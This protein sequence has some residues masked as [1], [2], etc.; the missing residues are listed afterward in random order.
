MYNS[1]MSTFARRVKTSIQP[2][3]PGARV[4]RFYGATLCY[5]A[6]Y[7]V[8]VCPFVCPS[9]CLSVRPSVCPSTC[10]FNVF[11]CLIFIIL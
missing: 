8:V 7:A 11:V 5:S 6:L 3:L 2:V 4:V 1:K 9:V 10:R